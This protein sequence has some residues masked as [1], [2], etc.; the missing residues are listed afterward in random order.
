MTFQPDSN[1]K[2]IKKL[3]KD[4]NKLN[5]NLIFTAGINESAP[6]FANSGGRNAAGGIHTGPDV[7]QPLNHFITDVDDSGASTGIFDKINLMSSNVVIDQTDVSLINLKYILKT[8]NN[9]QRIAALTVKAGKTLILQTGGNLD[10][11]SNI[12]LSDSDI[13]YLVYSED[14]SDK[15][16]VLSSASSSG[17]SPSTIAYI[18][19]LFI[20]A[21]FTQL[22]PIE[23]IREYASVTTSGMFGVNVSATEDLVETSEITLNDCFVITSISSVDYHVA[24]A[25][26]G[27]SL[28]PV[29]FWSQTVDWYVDNVH[30]GTVI[31]NGSGVFAFDFDASVFTIGLHEMEITFAGKTCKV[32]FLV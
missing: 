15:Y 29:S 12:T 7:I 21:G 11:T 25:N 10:I 14:I 1:Y 2:D 31:L 18:N 8:S 30:Q 4:L 9:G 17:V 32:P 19:T 16:R 27:G 5:D 6:S 26:A 24:N 23:V 20:I 3:K 22:N 13:A 28:M